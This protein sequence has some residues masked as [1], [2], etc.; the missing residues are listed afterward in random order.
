MAAEI[1]EFSD[2]FV[3]DADPGV[4]ESVNLV[5]NSGNPHTIELT[6]KRNISFGD[7][8]AARSAAT[9]TH[10]TPAGQQS[11]D[12]FDDMLFAIHL[13]AN[14][15]KK[16]PF[17]RNGVMVPVTV[18]YVTK[19]NAR[20]SDA[21]SI[22]ATKLTSASTPSEGALVDFEKPSDVAF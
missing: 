10:I 20:N 18:E 15:I 9:K 5:D 1:F 6:V 11:V 16:W 12:G 4:I 13:L 21:F 3:S 8:Q 14:V 7:I 22:L 2:F 19:L 17:T